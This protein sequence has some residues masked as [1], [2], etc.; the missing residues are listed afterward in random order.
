LVVFV[1]VFS[2]GEAACG[3]KLSPAHAVGY[4]EQGLACW[5]DDGDLIEAH[6]WFNL[7]AMRGDA[8]AVAARAEVADLLTRSEIA[9]AQRRARRHLNG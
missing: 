9:E 4:Y 5:S 7:A 8:D 2:R 1:D 3:L 6:K